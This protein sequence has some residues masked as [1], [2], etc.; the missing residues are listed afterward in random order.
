MRTGK[1]IAL[2]LGG[3]GN[4]VFKS[5]DPVTEHNFPIDNFDKLISAG[6]IREDRVEVLAPVELP[7]V[8]TPEI[9]DALADLDLGMGSTK[10]KKDKHRKD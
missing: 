8:E 5:G 1:V 4:K 3:L 6:F 2:N 7:P 10:N 9:K